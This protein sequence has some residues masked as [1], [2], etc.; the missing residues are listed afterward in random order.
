MLIVVWLI[1]DSVPIWTVDFVIVFSRLKREWTIYYGFF[2]YLLH[3][4]VYV[5]SV[6]VF[7]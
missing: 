1:E 6:Y 3:T 4:D 5:L 7:V 2:L